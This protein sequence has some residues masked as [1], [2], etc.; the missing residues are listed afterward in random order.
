MIALN[1][2]N[3]KKYYK[4]LLSVLSILYLTVVLGFAT[5]SYRIV[6]S[7]TQREL[8]S[9]AMILA[10][11]IAERLEMDSSEFDRLLSL[12]FNQLLKDPNNVEFEQKARAVMKY[13]D[14]K[15]IYLEAP[16]NDDNASDSPGA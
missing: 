6:S 8:G 15:Y 11:D 12:E 9:K 2:R 3:E 7:D 13:T 4:I 10:I 16:V 1:N 5:I 14:I